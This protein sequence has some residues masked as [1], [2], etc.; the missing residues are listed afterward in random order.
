VVIGKERSRFHDSPNF[1]KEF[2]MYRVIS[3]LGVGLICLITA[4]I[5]GIFD[6]RIAVDES[7]TRA[8]VVFFIFLGV[9]L[10]AFGGVYL[11]RRRERNLGKS[12]LPE[13]SFRNNPDKVSE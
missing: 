3:I 6:F 9:V 13:P 10:L 8:T 1:I 5:F 2:T 7:W 12:L 4:L 11:A